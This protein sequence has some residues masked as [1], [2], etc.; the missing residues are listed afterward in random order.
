MLSPAPP[1]KGTHDERTN[2]DGSGF[3][4]LVSRYFDWPVDIQVGS[5]TPARS[6]NDKVSLILSIIR[7]QGSIC[8][9]LGIA[10]SDYQDDEEKELADTLSR[11]D[12]TTEKLRQIIYEEGGPAPREQSKEVLI[13]MKAKKYH[14]LLALNAELVGALEEQSNLVHSEYCSTNCLRHERADA[15]IRRAKEMKA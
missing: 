8:E 2:A 14:D 9:F 4:R 12:E 10:K 3:Y 1:G 11:L 5:M 13:T 15:L 6:V 7:D